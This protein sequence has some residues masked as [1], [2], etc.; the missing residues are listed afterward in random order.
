MKAKKLSKDYR[1]ERNYG[2]WGDEQPSKEI[3]KRVEEQLKNNKMDIIFSHTCPY[4]YEPREMFLSCISQD[5]VDDS[6]ERWLD[7][8]EESIEYESWYCGH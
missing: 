1:L 8:I 2:L 6:T 4:K 3:K 7:I 5:T